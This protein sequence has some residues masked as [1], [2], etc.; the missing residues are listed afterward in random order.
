MSNPYVMSFLN[1]LV[2]CL[3]LPLVGLIIQ[4]LIHYVFGGLLNLITR[5]G[6][7]FYVFHNY[8][9]AP[10]VVWHE[11]S[12]LLV[13]I[14]T[15]AQID[16]VVLFRPSNDSL[17]GVFFH[18]RGPILWHFVQ[19]TLIS[20]APVVSGFVAIYGYIHI[21]TTRSLSI[22]V[23][24][25]LGYLIVCIV[26]HMTMSGADFELYFKGIWVFFVAFFAWSMYVIKHT[27]SY[28]SVSFLN[29]VHT[30]WEALKLYIATR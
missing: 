2:M 29:A 10:G 22:P 7:T 30:T 1:A 17:G 12:H 16:D 9:T 18:P 23:H 13:A 25:L 20:C 11:L 6:N 14:V 28:E 26:I 3:A 8:L 24:I 5:N 27:G 4:V 19:M 21:I 15:F